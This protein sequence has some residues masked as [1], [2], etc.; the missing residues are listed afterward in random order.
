MRMKFSSFIVQILLIILVL[1]LSTMSGIAQDP[2]S[3]KMVLILPGPIND[4]SWNAANYAGLLA[5]NDALGT[6]MEYVE[7]VQASDFESTFRNYG[8]RG[9]DL[10]ISAGTQFDEAANRVGPNYPDT[11]YCVFNGMIANP[12][13]VCPVLPKE[14]EASFLAGIV[15]G[16]TT[17]TGKIGIAGG[18]PNKLMIMLLNTFEYGARI[19]SPRVEVIRSYANSWDDVT[20]G[21]QM[22]GSMID[23]KADVLFFYANQVGLGAIQACKEKGAK[24]IGFASDQNSVAPGTVIASAWFGTEDMYKWIVT[25]YMSGNLEPIVNELGVSEG[26]ISI[27]FSDEVSPEVQEIVKRAE[28]LI[29]EGDLLQ[30]VSHFPESLD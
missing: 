28:D 30:F 17:E 15:A 6:N 26:V 27:S 3:Y 29:A 21:K 22:A 14:Y 10:V 1:S 16:Y 5:C 12:P 19:G 13:N 24:F 23:N 20:L 18:F 7:N 2:G 4:Q 25:N 9:Y 11:T 8:E